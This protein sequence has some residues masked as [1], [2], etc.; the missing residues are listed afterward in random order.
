MVLPTPLV[1]WAGRS[2]VGRLRWKLEES[3]HGTRQGTGGRGVSEEGGVRVPWYSP[4]LPPQPLGC[5]WLFSFTLGVGCW[6]TECGVSGRRDKAGPRL[7]DHAWGSVL[8]GLTRGLWPARPLLEVLK[9]SS[10]SQG[11][12]AQLSCHQY[13]EPPK[14][15]K[16]RGIRGRHLVLCEVTQ[17]LP[18]AAAQRAA[19]CVFSPSHIVGE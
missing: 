18:E 13:P 4:L 7:E 11:S 17:A 3:G 2:V 9:E 16:V 8:G 1:L 6:T 10:L 19:R 15:G 14:T 5:P 12:Q